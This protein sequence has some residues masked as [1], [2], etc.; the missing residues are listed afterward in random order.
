M[1]RVLE[2]NMCPPSEIPHLIDDYPYYYD[3]LYF[4]HLYP[5]LFVNSRNFCDWLA[6]ALND[7]HYNMQCSVS[8]YAFTSF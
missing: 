8:D 7:H 4:P 2:E 6:S 1:A 5:S 3:P